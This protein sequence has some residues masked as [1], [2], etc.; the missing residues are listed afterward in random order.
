MAS[1]KWKWMF[2]NG[3]EITNVFGKYKIFSAF[4][5]PN[6]CQHTKGVVY[7]HVENVTRE[8]HGTYK[9]ALLESDVEIAV[10]DVPFYG[11]FY[12]F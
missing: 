8:D 6:S 9:C 5:V 1:Y 7:L 4:S 12:L 11:M 10:E 2:K 3:R